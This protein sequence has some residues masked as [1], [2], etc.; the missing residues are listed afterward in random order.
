MLALS[1]A[2][3]LRPAAGGSRLHIRLRLRVKHPMLAKLGGVFDWLTIVLLFRGLRERVQRMTTWSAPVRYAEV[4]G[5]GV[6]FNSHY[7][8]YCDEAMAAYCR[9]RGLLHVAD[10][11]QL[12]TSTLTWKSGARWGEQLAVDV[13]CTRV[14]RTSF[15]LSFD[16]RADDRAVLSGRDD[17]RAH[18]RVMAAHA[19]SRRCPRDPA[20][21]SSRSALSRLPSCDTCGSVSESLCPPGVRTTWNSPCVACCHTPIGS[22]CNGSRSSARTNVTFADSVLGR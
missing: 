4:D 18:R 21:A 3:V 9:E 5:Q 1:W 7:L 6:V 16:I 2:L 15:A 22:H 19:G 13:G 11:V 20:H 12:V 8:L 10:R 14:G 17:L